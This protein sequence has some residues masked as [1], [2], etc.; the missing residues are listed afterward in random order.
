M[1]QIHKLTPLVAETIALCYQSL[2]AAQTYA[3]DLSRDR[4]AP[5]GVQVTF[6]HVAASLTPAIQRVEKGIPENRRN[7]F[8]EQIKGADTLQ[9]DNI[10]ALFV[11]MDKDQKEMLELAAEAIL[12]SELIVEPEKK[13]A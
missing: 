7:L 1:K 3:R 8:D 10:K 4:N 9:L 6:A 2:Q 13:T 5:N 12:K 11:R